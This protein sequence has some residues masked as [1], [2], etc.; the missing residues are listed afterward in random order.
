M[1]Q[2][3]AQDYST[4]QI[5]LPS[6]LSI[7]S[8]IFDVPFEDFPRRVRDVDEGSRLVRVTVEIFRDTPADLD[9]SQVTH[10]EGRTD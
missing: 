2:W 10:P 4:A 6:N 9:F 8:R 1:S 7:G 5:I 3:Q